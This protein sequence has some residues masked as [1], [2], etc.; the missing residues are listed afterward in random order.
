MTTSFTPQILGQTEKALNAILDRHL[1][2]TGVTEPQWVVLT[3]AVMSGGAMAHEELLARTADALK[4]PHDVGREYVSALEA[5]GLFEPGDISTIRVSEA[6]QELHKRV[7]TANS[8]LTQ[9][10]WGDL[11]TEDLDTTGR[12]LGTILERANAALDED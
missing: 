2:G 1:A 3:L 8:E 6:G 5:A 7:R 9:R 11:P 4:V 12:V 10:M